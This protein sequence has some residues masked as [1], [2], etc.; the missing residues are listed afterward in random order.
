MSGET[1][2][3]LEKVL[4]QRLNVYWIDASCQNVGVQVGDYLLTEGKLVDLQSF[5]VEH[6]KPEA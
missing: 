2:D 5:L 3:E 4:K 6:P 1:V